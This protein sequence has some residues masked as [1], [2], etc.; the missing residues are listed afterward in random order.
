MVILI[1]AVALFGL[2]VG[3]FLNVV[4]HRVPRG[5]S[6]V[7]PG[8]HCPSCDQPVR[9]RHN[10]PIVGWLMLRG[11]CADC[12]AAISVRYP[13]VEL[14]TALLFVAVTIQV[15]HLHLTAALPAY[16]FFAAVAVALS[17]ID[18]DVLRLPNA[19]V[20]PSYFVL[21]ALLSLAALIQGGPAPLVRA[22]IGAAALFTLYL[23]LAIA[24][25]VGMGFGDVKL[26]GVVG[27]ALGFLSYSALVIGAFAA[28]VIG[29][30][31]ATALLLSRSAT[32]K[33]AIPFGPFM[34]TGALVALFASVPLGHLYSRLVHQA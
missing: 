33:S 25:P 24:Y 2:A 21:G 20:Y 19:I 29:A 32:R 14:V 8:S 23:A 4:I 34:V 9:A 28:F 30:C 17:A 3:S 6:L 7:R 12:A 31:V 18:L 26:A 5:E 10:L 15:V 22:A 13:L 27:G 16:L 11:R 1:A